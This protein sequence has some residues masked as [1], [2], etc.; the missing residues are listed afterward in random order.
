MVVLRCS[1]VRLPGEVGEGDA[2]N[3]EAPH[4]ECSEKGEFL[5]E[6][7]TSL[8][9]VSGFKLKPA[10]LQNSWSGGSWDEQQS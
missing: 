3:G 4:T 10:G 8:E 2:D 9:I 6:P 1:R 7:R 5:P